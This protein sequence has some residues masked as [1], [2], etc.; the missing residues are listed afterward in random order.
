MNAVPPL[1]CCGV[2]GCV[3]VCVCA[4][5]SREIS[6]SPGFVVVVI[7]NFFLYPTVD[8]PTILNNPRINFL[9]H[10]SFSLIISF[11]LDTISILP[12]MLTFKTYLYAFI[13]FNCVVWYAFQK[14][15]LPK[16]L[17]KV[18]SSIYFWPTFPITA[19]L[20]TGNYWTQIDD[21]VHIINLTP[22]LVLII[23]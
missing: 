2:G 15:M 18:V 3:C 12:Q 13:L 10:G 14:K 20:R 4:K 17:T 22:L 23:L 21:T 11:L 16:W 6:N 19:L 8:Q 7:I 1:K 9:M 5:K